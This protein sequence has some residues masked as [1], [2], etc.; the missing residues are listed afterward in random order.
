MG[1]DSVSTTGSFT[2]RA[3]S[4]Q[5][6]PSPTAGDFHTPLQTPS[7][8]ARQQVAQ[9]KKKTKRGGKKNKKVVPAPLTHSADDEP[10][11][12]QLKQVEGLTSPKSLTHRSPGGSMSYYQ[13]RDNITTGS[14]TA[15]DTSD[16]TT[17]NEGKKAGN[18]VNKSTTKVSK[19]FA[20]ARKAISLSPRKK[21]TPC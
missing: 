17:P 6:S 3:G 13:T 5:V 21:N 12:E 18:K 11:A 2:I 16:D 1:D 14:A 20:S 9:P 10:F 4:D 7:G 8:L 19:V 15:N